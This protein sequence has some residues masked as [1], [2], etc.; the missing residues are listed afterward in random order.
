MK[1]FT[2]CALLFLLVLAGCG[3]KNDGGSVSPPAPQVSAPASQPASPS[4]SQPAAP[5][6]REIKITATNFEY[7]QREVHVKKGEKIKLTFESKE[8]AHGLAIPDLNIDLKKSGSV[9]FTAEKQG[10][11]PMA[12]SVMC[13]AGHTKMT[14]KIIVE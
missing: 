11:F 14:G 7:D 9:E 5:E 10:E 6:V 12:C 2:A 13:G 1:W 4:A 8:G 3:S